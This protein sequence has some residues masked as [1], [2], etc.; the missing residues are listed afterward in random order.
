MLGFSCSAAG[1]PPKLVKY[2]E[3]CGRIATADLLAFRRRGVISAFGRGVHSHTAMAGWRGNDTLACLETRELS[4]CREVTLESQVKRYPGRIDVFRSNSGSRWPEFDAV[5]AVG[6]MRDLTG[7]RYG[8][9]N[10]LVASLLHLPWLRLF[11]KANINDR[12]ISRWPPFCSQ[13]VAMAYRAGGVDPV[14]H[15]ADSFT[16]PAD[17]V[18]SLFFRYQFTLVP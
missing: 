7:H 5:A 14:P 16:E 18:R 1:Q 6:F 17:L 2:D 11:L 10:V 4:G 12:A 9:R 15:L 8:W 3:I 13:A